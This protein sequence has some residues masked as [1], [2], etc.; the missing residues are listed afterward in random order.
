MN[1]GWS[2]RLLDTVRDLYS[3]TSF[4]MKHQGCLSTNIFN[5]MGVNQGGNAS[6]F[7]FRKYLADLSE[8]LHKEVGVCVGDSILAHLLWAD[9]LIL[10]F[11][12]TKR[13]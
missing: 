1:S 3:K 13:Y 7:L 5:G 2:G 4:R 10:F 6:G 12:F 9:D 8:Y 11:G